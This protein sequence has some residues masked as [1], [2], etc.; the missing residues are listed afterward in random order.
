MPVITY[1]QALHD[2]MQEEMRRDPNV[3]C[4]G[5]EIGRFG[6][7]YK[8]T[9]GLL[10]E[11]GPDRILATPISE[12]GIVG[13]ATG[14][15]MTGLRPVAEIMTINFLIVGMDQLVNNAAKIPYMF[16]GE[17]RTP[18]V[19]R[20]PSGAGHQL[21]AQHSQ[22]LEVWFA[23]VPGMYVVAPS[24]PADAKGLL[25]SSIR[26]DN[27]VLFVENVLLYNEKGEVPDDDY[28]IPI[29]QA[30]VK[31][32]G[33]D[34]TI[35]SYSR[36]VHVALEAAEKLAA[37]GISAEVIDL[38][39]LRPLDMD[40]VLTSVRKTNRAII[41]HE[42]WRKYGAGAEIAAQIQENAFDYLDHP[43]ERVTGV[44]VPLPYANSLERAA[45]PRLDDVIGKSRAMV[46]KT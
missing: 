23:Y 44:E 28:T 34:L 12:L 42:G 46:G 36:M 26:D 14:A 20:T 30:D 2:A 39:S 8:V 21:T 45:L 11:F 27:P 3:F 13:L 37:D 29:G 43:V 17:A 32:E 40:T 15:A 18:I 41:V 33:E 5:E 25:K 9:E 6:G 24:T 35:I 31:R 1:R 7:S 10:G 16:G 19:V 4:L 22:V 38:R